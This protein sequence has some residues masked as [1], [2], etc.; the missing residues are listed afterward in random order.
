MDST[1]SVSLYVFFPWGR[2]GW[3]LSGGFPSEGRRDS[4]LCVHTQAGVLHSS[5][6]VFTLADSSL[7]DYGGRT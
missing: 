3:D 1:P 5:F 7:I 6:G 4:S 2:E